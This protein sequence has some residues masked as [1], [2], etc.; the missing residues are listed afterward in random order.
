[1]PG[2][3]VLLETIDLSQDA[4]TVVFDNIPQTGY[5]DLKIVM[6]ARGTYAPG[7]LYEHIRMVFN[8]GA[9]GGDYRSRMV[10]ANGSQA[11]SADNSGSGSTYEPWA[12]VFCA[13]NSTAN[14]YSNCEI[15]IED[16]NVNGITKTYLGNSVSESQSGTNT[17]TTFQGMRWTGTA[18]IT[19]I[20]LYPSVGS[21]VAGSTFSIYGLASVGTTPA[22]APKA[23]GGNIVA[24]DGTYW[25]HAFLS[26]GRF[27]PQTNLTCDYLIVA[28]GGGGGAAHSGGGGGAGG[29]LYASSQSISSQAPMVVAVG[30]GGVGGTESPSFRAATNGS[31]SIFNSATAFGGGQGGSEGLLG[32]SGGSGGGGG[33]APTNNAGQAGTTGQGNAGGSGSGSGGSYA[34]GGGGGGASAAGQ[35]AVGQ[36]INNGGYGGAGGSGTSTYSS[37]GLVTTTGHNVS[38]TVFFA[39]GGGGGYWGSGNQSGAGGNG[40]GGKGGYGTSSIFQAVSGLASTGGGGGG[41]RGDNSTA[42]TNRLGGAGGSGVVIIRYPMAS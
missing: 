27:I 10:Y 21:F 15:H 31:N 37:W 2:N 14:T 35:N 23:T 39:G 17:S 36:N 5:N 40:G 30:A 42:P 9:S 6:S 33:G 32:T 25:Y 28:G 7:V 19:S 24:N 3:Y 41:G 1:M 38:G 34:N 18:P 22:I 11:L 4:A 20:T 16:Y 12:G 13:S 8:G 26:S 29:V